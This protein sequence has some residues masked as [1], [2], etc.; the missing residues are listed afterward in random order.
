[1]L[2]ITNDE[3]LKIEKLRFFHTHLDFILC[4]MP[5]IVQQY[6][7]A[8]IND[9]TVA[10]LNL[11]EVDLNIDNLSSLSE[12][13][14]FY[15]T[16]YVCVRSIDYY[17]K[18]F[19]SYIQPLYSS[20]SKIDFSSYFFFG[21]TASPQSD[22]YKIRQCRV[23][24]PTYTDESN[25]NVG[26][27]NKNENFHYHCYDEKETLD[28]I[29]NTCSPEAL[30]AYNNIQ[31][32]QPKSDFF[33]MASLFNDGGISADVCSIAQTN[34]EIL[35]RNTEFLVVFDETGIHKKFMFAHPHNPFVLYHLNYLIQKM[36]HFG[37][38][39]DYENFSGLLSLNRNFMDF[40]AFSYEDIKNLPITFLH[41]NIYD[42]FVRGGIEEENLSFPNDY[43]PFVIARGA[44]R[45]QRIVE[46]KETNARIQSSQRNF[47]MP[48]THNL[49]V[50][51]HDERPHFFDRI[52]KSYAISS[53]NVWSVE[54]VDLYG[55]GW[56]QKDGYFISLE[57]HLSDLAFHSDH[58]I[59]ERPTES[60][61][62]QFID[63]ECIIAYGAGSHCFGHYLVDELPRIG[64]IKDYLGDEFYDK[65]FIISPHVPEWGKDFLKLFFNLKDENFITIDFDKER[66]K[67][68]KVY[69]ASFPSRDDYNFH[70]YIYE[71][72]KQF[73]KTNVR[74]FRKICLS[75]KLCDPKLR[76]QRIFESR[77]F[78]ESL[79]VANGFE[80]IN[81]ETLSIQ[82]QIRLMA[83]TVC[84]VGEHGSAQ[85][86]SVF[87]PKGMVIGTLNPIGDVQVALGRIYNDQNIICYSDK[88]YRDGDN[89]ALIYDID[90]TK[91]V[92][93]F[94]NVNKALDQKLKHKR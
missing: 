76:H 24:K 46:P 86:A 64:L 60:N 14:L 94:E 48:A 16:L 38:D 93:F 51:G 44:L 36:D 90:H 84:Q 37:A 29:T 33:L 79:A 27:Y 50:I 25:I 10:P 65:K 31:S 8:Y 22:L 3:N 30:A 18:D 52:N 28:Y 75:R 85:H 87:N 80:I 78:F 43:F 68:K 47:F 5:K 21:N 34:L 92:E 12:Q 71:F 45:K 15:C 61:I 57:S 40:Y 53:L 77:A 7:V 1:M 17:W 58:H 2:Y 82:E 32:P 19:I 83:E 74:P 9:E 54:N 35:I 6:V 4:N 59:W 55:L 49:K 39:I 11:H 42:A 26:F 62:T 73:Y 63:E 72:Y 66:W 56:V 81:P 89:Y 91:L 88:F 20:S 70:G 69:L 23:D 41:N 67:L 13:K